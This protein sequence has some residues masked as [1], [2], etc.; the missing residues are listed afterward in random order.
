MCG[1]RIAGLGSLGHPRILALSRWRGA[2]IAR[3]AKAIRPSAWVWVK[4]RLLQRTLLRQ[5]HAAF[6]SCAR[7]L[8]AFPRTLVVRRL[9]PDCSRIEL[10]SLSKDRDETRLLYS[11]GWNRQYA[12]FD[13]PSNSPVKHDLS[14]R[15][16]RW[17]HKAAKSMLAATT[18]DCNKWRRDWKRSAHTNHFRGTCPPFRPPNSS[19]AGPRLSSGSVDSHG[20]A[21]S[22]KKDWDG[23]L[24]RDRVTRCS[25]HHLAERIFFLPIH[26]G[27][28]RDPTARH[29]KTSRCPEILFSWSRF[30]AGFPAGPK[31]WIR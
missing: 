15:R 12:F 21:R 23:K 13:A 20:S 18:K 19:S 14:A 25:A 22:F 4:R 5:A 10:A 8:R 7:S 11:M 16:G 26:N 9:A 2:F 24:T 17:L 28:R 30:A 1:R 6:D 29:A 3:E 27:S 31:R